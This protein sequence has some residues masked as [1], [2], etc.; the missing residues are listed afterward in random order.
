M[1]LRIRSPEL[2][3]LQWITGDEMRHEKLIYDFGDDID[4]YLN[5]ADKV[6]AVE[7]NPL[8][9]KQIEERF[10]KKIG[11]GRLFIENCVV[12]SGDAIRASNSS[13][14]SLSI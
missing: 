9:C 13:T 14:G 4:Y 2:T 7:A 1:N 8:L 5:K 6:V 11:D 3:I 10:R 12:T